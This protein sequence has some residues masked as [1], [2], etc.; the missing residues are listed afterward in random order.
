MK[1]GIVIP[2]FNEEACLPGLIRQIEAQGLGA[3]ICVVDDSPGD[4]AAA[5][6]AGLGLPNLAVIRRGSKG[7]RGSAVLEGMRYFL[8]GPCDLVVEMD[9][10]LSHPPSRL[11]GLIKESLERKTD[12]LIASRYLSGSSVGGRPLLRRCFSRA[13]NGLAALLLGVPV[14]DYTSGFRVY[15]RRAA[16]A[17][18]GCGLSGTGFIVL[19]EILVNLYYSGQTVAE[20]PVAFTERRK[21]ESSLDSKEILGA[22]AGLLKVW[23]LKKKLAKAAAA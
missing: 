22:F 19:S 17:A 13:A 21:G 3:D 15:S 14:K 12:L 1:I 11:P 6:L 16:E 2:S 10:D 8:K 18:A 4:A 23:Q 7:G 5:A 20:A 9:A